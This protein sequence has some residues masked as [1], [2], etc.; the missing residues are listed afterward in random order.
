MAADDK[1]AHAVDP[2][3]VDYMERAKRAQE[4]RRS[5]P[6]ASVDGDL[7][8][9]QKELI[10][11]FAEPFGGQDKEMHFWFGDRKRAEMDV[12]RGNV[13]VMDK[14]KQ[15][16]WEGDPMWMIPMDLHAQDLEAN[17]RKSDRM[18]RNRIK[19][20]EKKASDNRAGEAPGKITEEKV[21]IHEPGTDGYKKARQEVGVVD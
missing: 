6:E 13:P 1:K 9:P 15:V 10:H 11:K 7:R 12:D 4:L 2:R 8:I 14:G 20:D 18:L 3:L 21:N 5:A 16:T 19:T 17:K